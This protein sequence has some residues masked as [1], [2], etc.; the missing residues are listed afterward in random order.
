MRVE[1]FFVQLEGD[2]GD[3]RGRGVR[4][5]RPEV[6]LPAPPPSPAVSLLTCNLLRRVSDGDDLDDG[7]VEAGVGRALCLRFGALNPAIIG[8]LLAG[9]G[10][11]WLT[12]V[13]PVV[14]GY[15]WAKTDKET[16]LHWST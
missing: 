10:G 5:D 14:A 11:A 7:V 9:K 16:G 2:R 3:G 8:C 4:V 1:G 15:F 12:V 13:L 6:D